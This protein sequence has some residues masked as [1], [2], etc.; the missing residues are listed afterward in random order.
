MAAEQRARD[1]AAIARFKGID[2]DIAGYKFARHPATM[3]HSND[4][5]PPFKT[6]TCTWKP[7]EHDPLGPSARKDETYASY[8]A[9]TE[10]AM[11]MKKSMSQPIL[12]S[13]L[14]SAQIREAANPLTLETQRWQTIGSFTQSNEMKA[15][16]LPKPPVD[17]EQN[18][19]V[20]CKGGLVLFPKYMLFENSHLKQKDFLRFVESEKELRAAATLAAVEGR[21]LEQP[22][23]ATWTI[24]QEFAKE[25]RQHK[26]SGGAPA[27]KNHNSQFG[28]WAG[29]PMPCGRGS[30]TSNP[31]RN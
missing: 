7:S 18:P 22:P 21:Q 8:G 4:P 29:N 31:F 25:N 24:K 1:Q 28:P 15:E 17:P 11:S 20:V 12:K 6:A 26:S 19:K 5:P 16:R 10:G 9:Y 13:T 27:L 30:R 14:S 23:S 2:P 3:G